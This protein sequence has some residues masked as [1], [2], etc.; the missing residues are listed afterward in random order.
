MTGVNGN[1]DEM[2]QFAAHLIKFAAD[3]KTLDSQTKARMNH[4]AQSWKDKKSQE[5]TEKYHNT[6]KA[7]PPL[8]ETLE[9]YSVYL[10]EAAA[11]LDDF[12]KKRI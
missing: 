2:R 7:L 1:P 6:V 10:K 9:G 11:I 12:L 8:L 4:L 3:I 5:F